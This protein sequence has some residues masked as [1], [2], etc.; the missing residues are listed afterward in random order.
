MKLNERGCVYIS[1]NEMNL[2]GLVKS[3]E[4]FDSSRKIWGNRRGNQESNFKKGFD[5]RILEAK[6]FDSSPKIVRI[7]L[8]NQESD[9][10]SKFDS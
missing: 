4:K 7:S 5:S 6:K 8:G 3:R 2:E 9:F 1:K 10:Q